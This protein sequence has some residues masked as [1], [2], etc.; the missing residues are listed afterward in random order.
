MYPK[1]RPG[2][3]KKKKKKKVKVKKK[4]KAIPITGHGGL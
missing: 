3:I 1:E 2:W 4:N